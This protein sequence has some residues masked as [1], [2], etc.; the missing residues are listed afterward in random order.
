MNRRPPRPRGGPR[1]G[2]VSGSAA[3]LRLGQ[4]LR[5]LCE[6]LAFGEDGVCRQE[7]Y[8]VFVPRILPGEL[9]EVRITQAGRKFGRGEVVRVLR[10]SP[11]RAEP[12]CRHFGDCGGCTWQHLKYEAQTR[13]KEEMLR[14]LL[15]QRVS[16]AAARAI[17][18]IVAMENPWGF[19]EKVQLA[20]QGRTGDPK[21]GFYRLRSHSVVDI[22]ECP[23]QPK[24]SVAQAL[25]A[26]KV[27][28]QRRIPVYDERTRRGALRHL[29]LRRGNATGDSHLV[30]VTAKEDAEGL[31]GSE[32]AFGKI[33]PSLTGASV[34]INEWETSIVLGPR[35]RPLF[36]R[37]TWRERVGGVLFEISPSSFFQTNVRAA[38]ALVAEVR[39][40]VPSDPGQRVLDLY[41]GCGLFALTLSSQ[42]G[43]VMAVEAHRGAAA[44]GERSAE[45]NGIRNCTFRTGPV[46]K[47]VGDPRM[48][49]FD[50][51]VADPPRE[52]LGDGVLQGIVRGC[53]ARRLVLVSC[54]PMTLARDLALAETLGGTVERVLPVDMFP[55]THHLE[56][57]A[58]VLFDGKAPADDPRARQ[59]TARPP[60]GRPHRVRDAGGRANWIPGKHR[61]PDAD[62]PSRPGSTKKHPPGRGGK[63][64]DRS[65]GDRPGGHR[66]GGSHPR[67]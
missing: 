67:S 20:V 33:R 1:S 39:R 12:R 21:V 63:H 25:A 6:D 49:R 18:P 17:V 35:T 11:D 26:K 62:P 10:P 30:L 45:L 51:V 4:V 42:V 36:G 66:P 46:E 56:S 23:V 40:A 22:E 59:R 7:G 44:D 15:E 29:V 48:G 5:L 34:N 61:A 37:R 57:V 27:I 28:W 8:V 53:R 32:A 43:E 58:T 47:Q 3:P 64:R 31:H 38:E 54:D 19:R 9:A 50:T 24:E 60:D 55:H 65:G 16:P 14:R 13:R 52:G 41:A 2:P